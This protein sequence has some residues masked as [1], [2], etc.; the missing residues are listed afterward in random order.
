[1]DKYSLVFGLLCPTATWAEVPGAK[2]Q[3]EEGL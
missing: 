1:M 3:A 2:P